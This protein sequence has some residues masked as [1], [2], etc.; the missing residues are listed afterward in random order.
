MLEQI[1]LSTCVKDVKTFVLHINVHQKVT[2]ED[3]DFNN[4]VDRVIHS[5]NSSQPPPSD[6]LYI[7]IGLINT[8]AV[9]QGWRLC[10]GLH[11]L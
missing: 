4:Q 1:D 6:T 8:A 11:S 2:S 9:V 10:M 3:E 7:A 5:M